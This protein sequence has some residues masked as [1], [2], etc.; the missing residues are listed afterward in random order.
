MNT[1]AGNDC[2]TARPDPA[3][4][5]RTGR[6][7]AMVILAVGA[8]AVAALVVTRPEVSQMP[9]PPMEARVEWIPAETAGSS[10]RIE[11]QG[12]V[13]PAREVAVMPR[14]TGEVIGMHPNFEPGGRIAAGDEMVRL[15]PKDYRFTLSD[16]EAALARA[17][18]DLRIERGQGEI[19]SNEWARAAGPDAGPAPELALRIPQRDRAEAAVRSA[20]TA[21]DLA[22]ENLERTVLRA[23]FNA[24]VLE[25]NVTLGSQATPQ[26]VLAKIASSDEYWADISVPVDR[27]AALPAADVH[28]ALPALPVRVLYGGAHERPGEVIRVNPRIESSGRT[29]R[30]IVRIRNPIDAHGDA[31][32]LMLGSYVRCVMEG[33]LPPGTAAVRIPRAAL[34][35]SDTVWI[36]G[37]DSQLEI[38]P[39]TVLWREPDT[40]V[41]G[42][43]VKAGE[44]V[45][46]SPISNP[47]PGL[48]LRDSA[49][50]PG[51]QP[52]ES[53]P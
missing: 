34:R 25:R 19:A 43:Q 41:I 33:A 40:V 7:L 53:R 12:V 28:G 38:R 37:G 42:A 6:I 51:T 50:G 39:V 22:A 21:R 27:L 17:D 16:R 24:V 52:A 35:E 49:D 9:P 30:L 5:E 18:A 23:P 4:R 3:P 45:V 47:I 14:V 29:A 15:D 31:P 32:G 48:P 26:S 11:A 44:R 36:F 1:S 13:I 20:A 46:T 10:V 2:D 8:L